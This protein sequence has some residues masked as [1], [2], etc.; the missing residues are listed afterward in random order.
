MQARRLYFVSYFES[1]FGYCRNK[2]LCVKQGFKSIMLM[3]KMGFCLFIVLLFCLFYSL[4]FFNYSWSHVTYFI[5]M[6]LLCFS[7]PHSPSIFLTLYYFLYWNLVRKG[8]NC[9][10]IHKHNFTISCALRIYLTLSYLPG[11]LQWILR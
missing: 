1:L 7:F 3:Q 4:F 11:F 10:L 2:A 8:N 6:L 9:A 5:I